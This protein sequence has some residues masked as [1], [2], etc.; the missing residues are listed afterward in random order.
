[1]KQ[2][3]D[4]LNY[5]Q[6]VRGYSEH[7]LRG[8]RQDIKLFFD[9]VGHKNIEAVTTRVIRQ[10][11]LEELKKNRS[12]RTRLR[13]LSSLRSFYRFALKQKWVKL[14]PFDSIERQKL[15]K[16]LPKSLNEEE[17]TLLLEQPETETYLGFRDRALL[18]LFYSSALRLSEAVALSRA[19]IDFKNRSLRIKGKGKKM[20]VVPMTATCAKWLHEYLSHPLRFVDEKER[21]SERDLN[22]VF[23]N[24]WGERLS[25]RSVERLL[26]KYLLKSGLAAKVTPHTFRHSIATHWLE[27]GMDLKT[28]QLLLGHSSLS[29][30]TIY[31][32]VTHELK[33]KVYDKAHPRA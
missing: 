9:F 16:P 10:Y 19:D 21:F 18:E 20:R 26:E 31:T 23:L 32:K 22:A 33:K 12:K 8:Y 24:K 14:N 17:I 11:L 28:I 3:D 15:D 27:R 1:M 5:L 4:Y 2:C 30:T 29:T 25:A 7:T 6:N 13:R